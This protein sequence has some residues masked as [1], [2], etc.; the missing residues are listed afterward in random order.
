MNNMWIVFFYYL[1]RW[2]GDL[3]WGVVIGEKK[4]FFFLFEKIIN[5]K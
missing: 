1:N 5:N 4:V 2:K 3:M